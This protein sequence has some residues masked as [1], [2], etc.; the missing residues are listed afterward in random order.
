MT[1][2]PRRHPV[3]VPPGASAAATAPW[4]QRV[5]VACALP[6]RFEATLQVA[7]SGSILGPIISMQASLVLPGLQA[8]ITFRDRPEGGERMAHEVAMQI[9]LVLPGERLHRPGQTVRGAP[10]RPLMT[11]RLFDREGRPLN[12]ETSIG[13]CVDGS[14]QVDVSFVADVN[15]VAWLAAQGWS[16]HG[17]PRLRLNGKLVYT[18]GVTVRLGFSPPRERGRIEEG[19]AEV[20]LVHPG[21]MFFFPE[22]V[23]EGGLPGDPWIWLM[24]FDQSGGPIGREQLIGHCVPA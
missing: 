9:P 16:G 7:E 1:E 21:T 20:P 5:S 19:A 10:R 18:R 13:E 24:F 14:R 23:V 22:R 12:E 15:A 4:E 6:T 2:T 8:R 11:L 3:L 17:G